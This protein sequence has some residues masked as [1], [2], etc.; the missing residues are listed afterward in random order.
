MIPVSDDLAFEENPTTVDRVRSS[1]PAN[2]LI[3]VRDVDGQSAA[4]RVVS[5]NP[6]RILVPQSRG[7]SV[8][9]SLSSF[10]GGVVAGDQTALQVNVGENARL[11]LGT[12]SSTKVYRRD[13]RAVATYTCSATVG[14]GGL[15][16]LA[17]DVLQP[18]SG[19]SYTQVQDFRLTS[20]S[21]LLL[22]DWFS[23]GRIARG[24]SWDFE[25]LQTRN[26]IWIDDQCVLLDALRLTSET[27]EMALKNRFGS[28]HVMGNLVVI[29][30]MFQPIRQALAVAWQSAGSPRS[31]SLVWSLAEMPY[32]ALVRFAATTWE[33]AIRWIQPWME[34]TAPWL[35]SNPWSRKAG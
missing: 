18:Y 12:Q 23:S 10:G 20:S 28:Y 24:E 31:R 33:D 16:V 19:S 9:A 14:N 17:P 7:V 34:H 4:T 8:W 3:H 29:G 6:L 2:A 26:R 15:L 1:S 22:L 13:H 21:G 35:G 30:P 25:K 32:G 5:A 27:G 11:Y